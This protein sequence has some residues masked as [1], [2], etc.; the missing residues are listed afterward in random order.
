MTEL[1]ESGDFLMDQ[2]VS[3]GLSAEDL[4]HDTIWGQCKEFCKPQTNE[5]CA[6]FYLLTSFRQGS[7]SVDEWYNAEQAQVNLVKSPPETAKKLHHDIF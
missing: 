7:R 6:N 1:Q 5:V 3:L 4:N 2:Y